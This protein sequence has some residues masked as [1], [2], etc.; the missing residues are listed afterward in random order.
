[1][2]VV[3]YT[4]ATKA[5]ILS[6][7]LLT[8]LS[9]GTVVYPTET[10]YGL[11]ADFF[12]PK[13]YRAIFTIKYRDAKKPLPVIVPDERYATTLVSFTPQ[14]SRLAS[15]YWP[16]PLTLVLPFLY[17]QHFNH[18]L[19]PYLAL[20]VSSHPFASSLARAFG[21]PLISTSANVSGHGVCYSVEEVLD[22]FKRTRVQPDLVIDAGVLPQ[23]PPS[24]IIKFD[25]KGDMKVIREGA[26][27]IKDKQHA[28]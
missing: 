5:S 9:G 21:K 11:G 16:G 6:E 10:M 20:R 7:A 19:D 24:T 13:A 4:P 1:M 2:K 28:A 8:L 3:T 12:S 26:I 17:G 23:S 25:A 27:R 22:H 14:A 15:E 18:H